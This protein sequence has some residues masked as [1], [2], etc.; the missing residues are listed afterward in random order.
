MTNSVTDFEN[1]GRSF[2]SDSRGTGVQARWE[3]KKQ[4]GEASDRRP[5]SSNNGSDR[6]IP[7]RS[8][9]NMDISRHNLSATDSESDGGSDTYKAALSSVLLGDGKPGRVLAFGDKAPEPKGDVVNNLNVLYSG[10]TGAGERKKS[11]NAKLVNRQISSAP[12]RILDAPDMLDDYYLNLLS[13]SDTNVL[14]VALDKTVYLWNAGNGEITELCNVEEE[15][16]EA[17]IASVAWVQ[18]GGAHIAVGTSSGK[19][20]LWD[21]HAGKQLRSMDGHTQRVSSMSWNDHMLSTGG[22]DSIVVNHDVRVA[23][24]NIATLTSH[25]QEVCQLAWSLDGKTLASGGNDN[26]L[27]L[28]DVATSS[29]SRPRFELNDHQAAVKALAWSPHERNL[30]ASGGGTADRTIKFWNTQT[31]SLLNSIDTDSQVCA[32][33]WNP[34]EKEI[35]SSHGFARNHL[36]LWKYPSMAKV[37][38]LEGHQ[39]RVLHMALSPD[40]GT[41]VSAAA[42]ETLRFWEVFAPPGKS[43]GSKKRGA[44]HMS[45]LPL[46][47]EF[48]RPMQIR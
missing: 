28:W 13:W 40:G 32:L 45:E 48:M 39:S 3:R 18:E 10:S 1:L 19:T 34:Y 5:L 24:H 37:K 41:V 6:F 29:T 20:Q 31:G 17:H 14:A 22:R 4:R 8:A 16:A 44:K 47:A 33:Q 42:D 2:A 36:C 21:V 43:K 11:S 27:C 46:S 30:L 23:R 12:A 35:L 15:G 25:T 26:K 7:N 9:M 38:E